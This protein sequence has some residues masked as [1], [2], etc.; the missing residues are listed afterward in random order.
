MLLHPPA[1]PGSTQCWLVRLLLEG[2]VGARRAC[3]EQPPCVEA[4]KAYCPRAPPQQKP[5]QGG[6]REEEE[7]DA[8]PSVHGGGGTKAP[9]LTKAGWLVPRP[10]EDFQAVFVSFPPFSLK[11]EQLLLR[12]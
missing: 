7:R 10:Q 5:G 6:G 11:E 4:R 12:D 8:V 1:R 3:E 2:G 9:P